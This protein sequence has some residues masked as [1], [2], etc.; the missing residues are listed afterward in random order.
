VNGRGSLLLVFLV[1]HRID[2][3]DFDYHVSSHKQNLIRK[4]GK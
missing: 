1:A 3:V 2:N 4:A